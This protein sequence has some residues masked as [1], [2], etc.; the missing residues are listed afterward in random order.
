MGS[1]NGKV[2]G[3]TLVSRGGLVVTHETQQVR[4]W[5]EARRLEPEFGPLAV[6]MSE[7]LE[8]VVSQ[9]RRCASSRPPP[10]TG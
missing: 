9:I 6:Y 10:R 1:N 5:D 2:K 8:E 4:A 7:L 3:C